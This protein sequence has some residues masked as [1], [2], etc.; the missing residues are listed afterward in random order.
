MKSSNQIIYNIHIHNAPANS[1]E[2]GRN[3]DPLLLL[4]IAMGFALSLILTSI[5]FI[6]KRGLPAYSK[7]MTK[8]TLLIKELFNPLK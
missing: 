3:S 4:T 6:S 2:P 7:M 5:V 1:P 8:I